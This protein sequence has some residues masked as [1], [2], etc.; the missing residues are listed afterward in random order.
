MTTLDQLLA[1]L[2][3]TS[4][5]RLSQE[6]VA[7]LVVRYEA[8]TGDVNMRGVTAEELLLLLMPHLS[9]GSL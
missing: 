8:E 2:V 5:H 9:L 7:N 3:S 4:G 1:A 6:E